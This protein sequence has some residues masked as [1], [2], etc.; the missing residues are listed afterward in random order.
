MKLGILDFGEIPYGN[1]A[2]TIFNQS[3]RLA[4]HAESLGYSRY[5]LGEHHEA[6]IAWRGP[7]TA[8]AVLASFTENIKIGAAGVSLPINNPL[9]IAQD[10]RLLQNLFP[11]RIDL[12][13]AKGGASEKITEE[14]I[15]IEAAN[16]NRMNEAHY[17]RIDKILDFFKDTDSQ[18][19]APPKGGEVPAVW[20]MS[21]TSNNNEY[22]TDRKLNLTLS[23]FHLK[24]PNLE[25]TSPA[26]IKDLKKRFKKKYRSTPI[27]N[28]A[29]SAACCKTDKRAK[30]ILA[31]YPNNFAI[32][33]IGTKNE[34]FDKMCELKE[35]YET[36]E[37]IVLDPCN[38]VKDKIYSME[39]M[40]ELINASKVLQD[41]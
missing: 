2:A 27:Y 8:M 40:A 5:W 15:T 31:A 1:N 13:I 10:S 3:I 32:N 39:T 6:S 26:I 25:P 24:A 12:G 11:G 19:V 41:F 37:I 35:A 34:V 29:I 20:I 16:K 18:I 22:V 28:I 14:L 21:T 36:N 17:R 9:R 23:L 38:D 7:L 33:F 4:R 30:E